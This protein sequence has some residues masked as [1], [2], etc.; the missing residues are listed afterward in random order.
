MEVSEEYTLLHPPTE[1][2]R[3]TTRIPPYEYRHHHNHHNIYIHHCHCNASYIFV[4]R[5]WIY[6]LVT[7]N[8]T[9]NVQL[10]E[11]LLRQNR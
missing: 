3:I 8:V 6:R 11:L 9:E 2:L 10:C 5:N 1:V 7:P 4:Q